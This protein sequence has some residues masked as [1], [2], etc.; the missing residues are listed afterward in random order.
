MIWLIG[1]KGMLASEVAAQLNQY[2][3]QWIGSD[4]EV[5]ITDRTSVETFAQRNFVTGALQW[6]I[7][8]AAYTAVDNAEDDPETAQKL[9]ADALINICEIAKQYGAQLIHFSTDY[10]F[11]GASAVPYT[12][13]DHPQ[14]QSVYGSTKLQ[15]ERNIVERLPEHY[16]IRTAWLYGKNGNNFVSTMLRLM[17]EKESLKVVN[18]Q[19]GSPTYAVDLAKAVLQIIQQNNH[20]Y[21][22]YHY[23]NEG[24]I[25]WYDFACEIYKQ[26][27]EFGL[28]K[29]DCVVAPCASNEFPQKAHRP[30]FSLLNKEKIK[31]AFSL[32][33]PQWNESLT[34]YLK[35]LV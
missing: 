34:A 32:S 19:R 26:G 11:D 23:S 16:I 6:I 31:A 29:S 21:G 28:I 35:E 15:G 4:K 22:I 7:N 10:V 20:C 9:N 27:K 18:D 1:S 12:E 25:T 3:I 17:N 14:P 30:S 5:D 24:N 2:S 13:A 8:C 33:I